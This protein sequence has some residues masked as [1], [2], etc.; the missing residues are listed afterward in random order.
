MATEDGTKEVVVTEELLTLDELEVTSPAVFEL[1]VGLM[2]RG[3]GVP[4]LG[5]EGSVGSGMML[6]NVS[7][8]STAQE[9]G[10]FR[11]STFDK[12]AVTVFT[13][14]TCGLSL[15]KSAACKGTQYK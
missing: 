5:A 10:N 12:V 4:V 14:L 6:G 9:N 8:L 1:A 7:K 13:L 2:G 11:L 15:S 3:P